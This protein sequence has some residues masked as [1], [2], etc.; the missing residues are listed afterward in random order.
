[1][2]SRAREFLKVSGQIWIFGEWPQVIQTV[3]TLATVTAAALT[4]LALLVNSLWLVLLPVDVALLVLIVT[5]IC[6]K[7][8]VTAESVPARGDGTTA[9][10]LPPSGSSPPRGLSINRVAKVIWGICL[11]LIFLAAMWL[12]WG[13]TWWIPP[14][15]AQ[16]RVALRLLLT[17]C[18]LF[19][20]CIAF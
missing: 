14:D 6:S 5:Y 18:A 4:G 13:S 9:P 3:F 12:V 16:F 19:G 10:N 1:T 20:L 15:K 11:L 2:D 7:I 8:T 17:A